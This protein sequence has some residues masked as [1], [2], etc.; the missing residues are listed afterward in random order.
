MADR[1]VDECS[2][3]CCARAWCKSFDFGKFGAN[4]ASDGRGNCVLADTDASNQIG[5][6]A[7]NPSYDL[8]E[9]EHMAVVQPELGNVGCSQHLVDIS[10]RVNAVCCPDGGCQNGAPGDCSEECASQWMPFA[11]RCS[12]FLVEHS[13][14]DA[15]SPLVAVT[16]LCEVAEFG[17]YHAGSNHGR[18]SDGDFQQYMQEMGPAC[19]GD[20][21]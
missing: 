19:C 7:S 14:A 6:T 3:A 15:V 13:G 17:R 16:E 10:G 1:T 4:F 21:L 2:N 8:Y 18:C 9:R 5:R 11:K 20:D 12:E